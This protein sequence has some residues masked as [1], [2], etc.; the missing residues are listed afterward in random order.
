[1]GFIKGMRFHTI[2]GGWGNEGL[3]GKL[4]DQSRHQLSSHSE[5]RHINCQTETIG[6]ADGEVSGGAIACWDSQSYVC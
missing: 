3:E 2:V 5:A 6:K 4:K 1:M